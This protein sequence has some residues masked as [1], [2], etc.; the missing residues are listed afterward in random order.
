MRTNF[1]WTSLGAL[2]L[3]GL[4]LASCQNSSAWQPWR[5][6]LGAEGALSHRLV[7]K[8]HLGSSRPGLLAFSPYQA[9]QIARVEVVLSDQAASGN[10]LVTE[11]MGLPTEPLVLEGLA[12]DKD[13]K[14]VLNAYNAAG[15]LISAPAQS[16]ET[17]STRP[18]MAGQYQTELLE[19]FDLVLANRQF[20]GLQDVQVTVAG[21][22]IDLVRVSLAEQPGASGAFQPLHEGDLPASGGQLRFEGLKAGDAYR[23]VAEAIASGDVVASTS[24]TYTVNTTLSDEE[25]LLP[26]RTLALSF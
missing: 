6:A 26:L 21:P 1:S 10:L 19:S 14:L 8:V 3:A 23:L 11:V 24:D 12:P 17:F 18:N 20:P 16:E 22:A 5:F 9:A 2:S 15:T 25:G 7:A 13:F 4:L